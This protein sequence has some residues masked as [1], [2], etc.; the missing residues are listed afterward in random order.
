MNNLMKGFASFLVTA[1]AAALFAAPVMAQDEDVAEAFGVAA[2]T[3]GLSPIGA[4]TVPTVVLDFDSMPA[5][6]TTVADIQ[7]AFPGSALGGLTFVTR[8]GIGTYNFQPAGRALAANADGSGNLAL[9]D[10]P[11]GD[12]GNSDELQVALSA[13][14]TEF[15]FEIGDWAGPFNIEAYNGANLIGTVQ[16]N[17]D[18]NNGP[19]F[20][21]ANSPFD[22]VVLTAFPQN[23]AANWVVPSLHIPEGGAGEGPAR[24]QVT[25][26]FNDDSTAEVDVEIQCDT[27]LPLSQPATISEGDGVTF[28][29]ND[30]ESG[31]MTC[32]VTESV[33]DGYTASYNDGATDNPDACVFEAVELGSFQTCQITNTLNEVD[34][35]VTKVWIDENPQFDAVNYAEAT[36]ACSN[37][38]FECDGLACNS[39]TLQF[40]GNPGTDSFSV[41]PRWDGMTVC[42]VTEVAIAD[43][44]VEIDDSDCSS[45]TV[46]PGVGGECTIYNTRLYAGIPTLSNY[47]LAIMALIM[48]GVGLVGFRRLV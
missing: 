20:V 12:F 2:P 38:A 17:T 16:V 31:A 8:A 45:I 40:N 11:A 22:N 26:N 13:P 27:G 30:F 42:A 33:P 10:P 43:G 7:A 15:G 46:L 18:G 44:G 39:G 24:F 1:M 19:F 48:L 47:G 6:A 29:V 4:M 32:V 5:G 28:V 3:G 36:W 34:V 21:Q 23:P 41:F 9:V 37:V 25:K 35:E 14:V